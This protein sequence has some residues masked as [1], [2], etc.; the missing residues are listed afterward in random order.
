MAGY[1]AVAPEL[2]I[3]SR[4]Q[5]TNALPGGRAA[6]LPGLVR[7]GEVAGIDDGLGETLLV[8]LG[9]VVPDVEDPVVVLAGELGAVGGPVPPQG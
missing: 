5:L 1:P 4:R 6:R 2:G 7:L 3:T 9:H 8:F